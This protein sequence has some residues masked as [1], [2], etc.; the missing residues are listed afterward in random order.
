MA[1][2][3]N[4]AVQMYLVGEGRFARE[5]MAIQFTTPPPESAA[6]VSRALV[7]LSKPRPG[8]A[9]KMP[10]GA[11]PLP[12]NFSLPHPIYQLDVADIQQGKNLDSARRVGW[13]F[14]ILDGKKTVAAVELTYSFG[15]LEFSQLEEGP[16]PE[17]TR[18]ALRLVEN[19]VAVANGNFEFRL[20]RA[21]GVYVVAVWLKDFRRNNDIFVPLAPTKGSSGIV[22]AS[23]I[24]NQSAFLAALKPLADQAMSFHGSHGESGGMPTQKDPGPN[25]PWK[26]SPRW[27]STTPASTP[28]ETNP[29][30]HDPWQPR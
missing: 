24:Q 29:A 19:T 9:A 28:A 11:G 21:P 23:L 25:D 2:A 10:H 12:L 15:R 3:L 22:G 4:F 5:K 27:S 1:A 18:E 30:P 6:L 14:L 7:T 13:R 20:L 8:S 16:F 26:R 17:A